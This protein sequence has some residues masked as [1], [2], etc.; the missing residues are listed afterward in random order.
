MGAITD[1][2][3]ENCMFIISIVIEK[4]SNG[5]LHNISIHMISDIYTIRKIS[6][7]FLIIFNALATVKSRPNVVNIR[8]LQKISHIMSLFLFCNKV[9]I[10]TPAQNATIPGN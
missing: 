6:M 1:M 4:Y 7:Y 9:V 10:Y 2:A 3:N 8:I 5:E